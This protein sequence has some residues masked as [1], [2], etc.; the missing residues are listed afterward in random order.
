MYT[1]GIDVDAAGNLY[2]ADTGNDEVASFTPSGQLRWRVGTRGGIGPGDFSNPRDVAV[3]GSR[4]Y[5][6][7]TDHA[8]VVVVDTATGGNPVRWTTKFPS[9]LGVGAGVDAAGSP[10]VLVAES[11]TSTIKVVRPDGTVIRSVGNGLGSGPGYL[12]QA[13]DAAT[14]AN[15]T[16]FVAD[17]KNQRVAVFAPDGTWLRSWGSAGTTD[18][19]FKDPYGIVLDDAG[20]VY[21][22]DNNRIQSFTQDGTFVRSW[23]V[24]GTGPTE[25]FQLRRVA[26]DHGAA[27]GVYAADLW[28]RKVVRYD[29]TGSITKIF[30]GDVPA[31]GGFNEPYGLAQADGKV[32]VTDVN[33]QRMQRFDAAT[34]SVELVWGHRG[35]DSDLSGVNW[36]RD[37]TVNAARNTIWLADTKNFRLLEFTRDGTPTGATLGSRGTA[38]GQLN[39]AYGIAS[40]GRDL[41]VAD[42]FGGRVSAGTPTTRPT[43]SG[44]AT[45]PG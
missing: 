33:N 14:S 19:K 18:G 8:S 11:G 20:L 30:G 4:L 6:A 22:S 21:V 23:G 43:R 45:P 12:N 28:G 29:A 16:I 44:G 42:S 37:L 39:W 9:L 25:L 31:D 36:P 26:V 17:F 32:Y 1:S 24:R 5:V 3:V 2:I 35:Y 7:D 41:I 10:V 34:R 27:P 38:L 40:Y 15:G 13:R